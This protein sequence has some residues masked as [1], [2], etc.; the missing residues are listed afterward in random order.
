M[1]NVEMYP[2]HRFFVKTTVDRASVVCYCSFVQSKS[3]SSF[4]KYVELGLNMFWYVL[5]IKAG[6]EQKVKYEEHKIITNGE[7]NG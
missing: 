3:L 2:N 1:A 4:V 5:F 6:H 7:K